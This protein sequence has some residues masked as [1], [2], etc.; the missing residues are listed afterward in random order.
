M[1]EKIR[2]RP[3]WDTIT[4]LS[5]EAINEGTTYGKLVAKRYSENQDRMAK[6]ESQ[7]KCARVCRNCGSLIPAR[8]KN[9]EFC[10]RECRIAFEKREED[11]RMR[12]AFKESEKKKQAEPERRCPYCGQIV[13]GK[14]KYCSYRCSYLFNYDNSCK[15]KKEQSA[16]RREESGQVFVCV[17]CGKQITAAGRRVYCGPECAREAKKEKNR[18]CRQKKDGM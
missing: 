2:I 13:T 18:L 3:E 1:A 9:M 14:K 7:K 17:R 8:S 10:C 15:R 16:R 11:A 4:K 5:T 12:G 6:E